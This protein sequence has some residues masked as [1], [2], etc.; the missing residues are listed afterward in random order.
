MAAAD[1][2]AESTTDGAATSG[3]AP[4]R[5]PRLLLLNGAPGAGKSTLARLL[6]DD[7]P[8]TLALDVDQLKHALGRWEEDARASGLRARELALALIDV[9]LRAGEDVVLGQYLAR[10]DFVEQLE[11]AAN[12]A[13]AEFREVLLDVGEQTL[14]TRLAARA[15][16]PAT[17]EQAVNA[18]LVGPE[19]AE[20]LLASLEAIRSARA[21]MQSVDATGDPEET[22]DAVRALLAG[23]SG[24]S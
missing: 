5:P 22:A 15:A 13:G 10:T 3:V 6:A 23:R 19:D 12:R 14:R 9:Q 20:H 2:A 24:R 17:P 8:L 7:R 11:A 16:R 18:C 1:P 21:H 4:G